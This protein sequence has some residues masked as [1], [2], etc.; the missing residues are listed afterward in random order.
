[1]EVC[2]TVCNF[3]EFGDEHRAVPPV[4]VWEAKKKNQQRMSALLVRPFEL[5]PA[6]LGE[7]RPFGDKQS[8]RH[9]SEC[10][11]DC[12][13]F[14]PLIGFTS[15]S[16]TYTFYQGGDIGIQLPRLFDSFC[17]GG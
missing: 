15:R 10:L 4:L 9:S 13:R 16:M 12:L 1:M 2:K 5:A 14:A 7:G 3:Q 8:R 6:S 17:L 11:L